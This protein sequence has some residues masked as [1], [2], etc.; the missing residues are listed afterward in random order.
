MSTTTSPRDTSPSGTNSRDTTSRPATSR[1]DTNPDALHRFGRDPSDHSLALRR[2]P[3]PDETS[4]RNRS[5]L[6]RLLRPE[7]PTPADVLTHLT[8]FVASYLA[9]LA[10]LRLFTDRS[11][12]QLVFGSTVIGFATPLAGRMLRLPWV[13]SFIASATAQ[14]WLCLRWLQPLHPNLSISG[15]RDGINHVEAAV[16]QINTLVVPVPALI[17]FGLLVAFASWLVATLAD[18]FL[19]SFRGRYEA[20][21]PPG[22]AV[23]IST[24]LLA[25]TI[26]TDRNLW[27]A[28]VLGAFAVHVVTVAGLERASVSNWFSHSH[29]RVPIAML[30]TLMLFG[31]AGLGAHGMTKRLKLGTKTPTIDWRV[32]PN[33]E[34]AG[35]RKVQSPLV[36]LRRRLLQQSDQEQ[37]RIRSVDADGNIVRSYWRQ[38]SLEVFDGELWRGSGNY[39][40]IGT[41]AGLAKA[42]DNGT[43]ITQEIEIGALDATSLPLAYAP[44]N[45]ETL[46]VAIQD[47]DASATPTVPTTTAKKAK[48]DGFSFDSKS[49][50]VL[51][52]NDLKGGQRFRAISIVNPVLSAEVLQASPSAK[53]NDVEVELPDSISPRVF[54]LAKEITT[55]QTSTV[56]KARAIQDYLRSNY[57]YSLDVPSSSFGNPLD[58][59]LFEDKTGYCQQFAGAFAA[60]ARAVGIPTRLAVG[61]TPGKLEDDGWFSVSGK[62]AHAW[63]EIRLSDG[64]WVAFEPTPGRGIPGA[65]DLTGVA[66]QQADDSPSPSTTTIASASTAKPSGPTAPRNTGTPKA[67]RRPIKTK[68]ADRA[69]LIWMF[70]LLLMGCVAAL[71]T[72]LR[73]RA[74]TQFVSAR[75]RRQMGRQEPAEQISFLWSRVERVLARHGR[76]RRLN[77]TERQY[78]EQFR[79]RLPEALTFADLVQRARYDDPQFVSD[80]DAAQAIRLAESLERSLVSTGSS[81][82]TSTTSA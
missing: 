74:K 5:R 45:L 24:V 76:R 63:P 42:R 14:L 58:S 56:G 3:Q 71:L 37:F 79:D 8:L 39:R 4:G 27:L 61:F 69:P 50:T 78:A 1:R 31:V 75:T 81:T 68:S 34:E 28:T 80:D 47:P 21:L 52:N 13:I 25:H 60:L 18:L 6:M 16:R 77:E 15:V 30:C 51:S 19:G 32:D 29:R 62:N 7:R 17:G 53:T 35:Q 70:G 67:K 2:P 12:S 9:A 22:T 23:I 41:G 65:E 55:G 43:Q 46:D 10:S 66:A 44:T 26:R 82:A 64:S 36:S 72:V 40:N 20:L 38:T 59:F 33:S 48:D 73:R 57:K 11:F 49:V 54:A